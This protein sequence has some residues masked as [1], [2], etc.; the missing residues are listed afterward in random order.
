[1][2]KKGGLRDF[3]HGTSAGVK[4]AGTKKRISKTCDLLGELSSLSRVWMKKR[5]Y[6][7]SSCS[8]G[9]TEFFPSLAKDASGSKFPQWKCVD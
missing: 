1:M 8:L 6:P 5:K 2:E 9:E 4:Q 7:V 3:E